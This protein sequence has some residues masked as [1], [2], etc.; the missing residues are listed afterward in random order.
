MTITYAL[1]QMVEKIAECSSVAK[2]V[3][4]ARAD[5]LIQ[6][7]KGD[8]VGVEYTKGGQTLKEYGI[9]E[10]FDVSSLFK[11]YPQICMEDCRF[12][13]SSFI[14]VIRLI[15]HIYRSG[16]HRYRWFRR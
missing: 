8:V 9:H 16:Y 1:I 11:N 4:K 14:D 2:V 3:T 12:D 5:K 15:P 7:A 6:N 13:A 10:V